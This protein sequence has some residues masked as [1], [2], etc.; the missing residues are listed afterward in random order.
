[1]TLETFTELCVLLS[2]HS[3]IHHREMAHKVA[4]RWL[5]ALVA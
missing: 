5:M 3:L 1:M 2:C 4:R